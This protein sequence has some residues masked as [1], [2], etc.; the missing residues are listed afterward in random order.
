MFYQKKQR[1]KLA[2][3][4][5]IRRLSQG[6]LSAAILAKAILWACV[7]LYLG[8]MVML[9][10]TQRE[11]FRDAD[12]ASF[13]LASRV[14][15]EHS[16]GDLYD[17]KVQKAVQER[18][19]T[20]SFK[21]YIHPPFEAFLFLPFGYLTYEKALWSWFGLNFTSLLLLPSLSQFLI[22]RLLPS[23]NSIIL[24]AIISFY[25]FYICLLTGQDSILLLWLLS[26]AFILLRKGSDLFA[27]LLLGVCFI[28]PQVALLLVMPLLVKWRT[29]CLSGIAICLGIGLLASTFWI[30]PG[31][32]GTY[33]GLLRG[34]GTHAIQV[35]PSQDTILQ[36]ANDTSATAQELARS[37]LKQIPQW[38]HNWVGQLAALGIHNVHGF[39][40]AA[41]LAVV[42]LILSLLIWKPGWDVKDSLF[43]LRLATTVL[44]SAMASL[45]LYL[46]D[47]AMIFLALLLCYEYLLTQKTPNPF[48]LP[49]QLLIGLSPFVWIFQT[50]QVSQYSLKI[51]VLWTSL[52]LL[53]LLLILL[54]NRPSQSQSV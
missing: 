8:N 18:M 30:G 15:I 16:A 46:H 52:L 13:Y 25:P 21:P 34:V 2:P 48:V 9:F 47:F 50:V 7:L 5:G 6:T 17:L 53:T 24:G 38:M 36:A 31:W 27:G 42:A 39:S 41:A 28:K 49:L 43:G 14:V 51:T 10:V 23:Q 11:V 12:F 22:P 4:A 33:A 26:L 45:H 40:G 1:S 29:R 37:S 54:K 44:L 19:G 35:S 32:V 20:F 3:R